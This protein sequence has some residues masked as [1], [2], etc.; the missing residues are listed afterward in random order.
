MNLFIIGSGLT[1]SIFPMAPLNADLL[2]KLETDKSDCVAKK[3]SLKYETNDIE[4]ALTKLDSDI[5]TSYYKDIYLHDYLKNIRHNIETSLGNYFL[6]YRATPDLIKQHPWIEQFTKNVFSDGDVAISLNYDC[7]FEGLLDCLGKWSP[8]SGYGFLRNPLI[9]DSDYSDSP[10]KVL[11]IHGSTS[12]K[13]S[14]Y[15]DKPESKAINFIFNESIFPVSAQHTNFGFGL[16]KG[17]T[18]LIAPS[19]VKIPSVEI[20]YLMLDALKA[21]SGSNNLIVIGCSLRPE[22]SFL[23]LLLTHFLRQPNWKERKII[24]ADINAKVISNK[25]KKYWGVNIDRC[26][27]PIENTID[28]S[29]KKLLE[30]I[31]QVRK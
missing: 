20:T 4:I 3:L 9:E 2:S 7:V 13:I 18:Y 16:G 27:I 24:V 31:E 23:T 5:S 8:I 17:E 19:Y 25:I 10:V 21:A 11:K 22:D 28:K 26:I 1:K 6:T 14:K 15:F 30:Q 12:F 29:I